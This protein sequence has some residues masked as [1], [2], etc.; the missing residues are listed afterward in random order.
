[1]KGL[2][3]IILCTL[4]ICSCGENVQ[5]QKLDSSYQ[6]IEGL[7]QGTSYHITYNDTLNRNFQLQVDSIIKVIDLSMSTYI[8]NSLISKCNTSL[9]NCELDE[10]MLCVFW[11]SY[12]V[13]YLTNGDFDPT[14]KPLIDFWGFGTSEITT[15]DAI[16]S[17]IVDSLLQYVGMDKIKL[18][19]KE[20]E[21][22]IEYLSA[23]EFG[24]AENYELIKD[25]QIQLDFNAIAQGY[26]V[27]VICEF[28][29][30]KEVENYLVEVGGEVRVKGKNGKGNPWKV[31]IDKP[32]EESRGGRPLQAVLTLDDKS[33]AT[34]G[35]YRK[36]RIKDG[37]KYSHTI[38]A[39]TGY[40]V[41]HKILSATVVTD[42]CMT[43][44]AFA[45]A[46]MVMGHEKAI[47]YLKTHP[48]EME[49][50]LIYSDENGNLL[51]YITPS[52]E[53]K[54]EEKLD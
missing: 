33:I 50:Y 13:H 9:T 28:L 22:V 41:T 21:E 14:V 37:V 18:F 43:A 12:E 4:L 42:D 34:S 31:G 29:Q 38:S 53:N 5:R 10:H 26:T 49:G 8:E 36:Y 46:F 40:P 19:D 16:D 25:G 51:S 1:M 15:Q 45:T 23:R 27:D 2:I 7:A 30:N 3:P 44:D 6:M 47:A 24:D 11:K 32:V 52:L 39:K 20:T 54:I 17:S 35:N 48:S